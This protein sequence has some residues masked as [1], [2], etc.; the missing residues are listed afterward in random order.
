MSFLPE[1]FE[2]P[3]KLKA[4][5]RA[6]DFGK[7]KDNNLNDIA[8]CFLNTTN[9]T[10]GS[11]GSPVLNARGEQV[12][13]AFDMTFEGVTGDY[14]IIPELQRVINVDMRYVLFITEKFSEAHHLLKEMK[15]E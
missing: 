5:H 4:L 11:S 8:T 7:Y 2:V 10:G 9:V 3:E 6:R 1:G 13:I 15:L 12:G 14:F